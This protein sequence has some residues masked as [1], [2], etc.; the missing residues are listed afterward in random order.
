M[1]SVQND[2]TNDPAKRNA[3]PAQRALGGRLVLLL[4]VAALMAGL[5]AGSAW[6]IRSRLSRPPDESPLPSHSSTVGEADA[7]WV[8]QGRLVFQVYCAS[9]HGPEGHG[10][11]PS[12]AQLRPPPR[13]LSIGPWK[14]GSSP[15]AVHKLISEGIP[16]TDMP[17]LGRVVSAHDLNALI[18]FVL[19]LAPKSEGQ[20]GLPAN[21]RS[22]LRRAGFT[23]ADA[24]RPAPA[25]DLYDTSGT[26][27]T[28]AQLRGKLVLLSFWG[29]T[30]APC[31]AE[32]P[33]LEHLEEEFHDA[34][35]RVL[36]VC[37]DEQDGEKVRKI[38]EQYVKRLPVYANQIGSARVRYDAQV[39]PTA[40]LI[41]QEGRLLGSVQG[42]I[43]WSRPEVKELLQACLSAFVAPNSMHRE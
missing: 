11:G 10:D 34:G 24:L 43:K 21:T 7:E 41:D 37:A 13:D 35:L 22:I 36:C 19:T 16:G 38:A 42:A 23:P 2:R 12:A 28:L 9:C 4:S 15:A 29:T 33:E 3:D 5:S 14:Y 6:L 18:A 40:F 1:E 26:R 39:L 30:C 27:L 25:L 17:A 32:L 31:L 20:A 8:A